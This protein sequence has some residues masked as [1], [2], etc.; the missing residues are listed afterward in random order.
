MR[1]GGMA[2]GLGLISR[3]PARRDTPYDLVQIHQDNVPTFAGKHDINII[4]EFAEPRIRNRE[5]IWL[6]CVQDTGQAPARDDPDS[7][8]TSR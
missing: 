8:R 6:Q 7:V 1:L 5:P 4:N 2:R 3:V